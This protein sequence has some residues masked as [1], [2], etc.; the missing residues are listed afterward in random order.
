MCP[1]ALGM[2]DTLRHA[3]PVEVRH[4]LH[5][6]VVLQQD[7]SVRADSK[8]VLVA[9]GGDTGIGGRDNRC[10]G[11]RVAPCVSVVRRRVAEAGY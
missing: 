3:L 10:I 5:E 9:G 6:I 4:L 11:H 1:A 2:D 8:R 7:R